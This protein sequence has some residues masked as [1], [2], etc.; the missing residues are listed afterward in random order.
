MMHLETM[1]VH[2]RKRRSISIIDKRET[3]SESFAIEEKH[4]VD[5]GF[6]YV[7]YKRLL[8]VDQAAV[9]TNGAV[10]PLSTRRGLGACSPG[11]I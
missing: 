3:Q 10:R 8:E 1:V 2:D 5:Q 11:K 6:Q 9:T 7:F 4:W